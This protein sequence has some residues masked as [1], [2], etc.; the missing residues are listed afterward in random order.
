MGKVFN[1]VARMV[2]FRDDGNND[3]T[4]Y[5]SYE[6]KL[7][8]RDYWPKNVPEM[9]FISSIHWIDRVFKNAQQAA[10]RVVNPDDPNTVDATWVTY[11]VG[12]EQ[13]EPDNVSLYVIDKDKHWSNAVGQGTNIRNGTLTSAIT[14][15]LGKKGDQIFVFL[16]G[17]LL[18][19]GEYGGIGNN[20]A[21]PGV[22][23]PTGG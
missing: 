4:I 9:K 20:T 13:K 14:A 3:N 16:Y 15:R 18:L 2:E 6:A 11:S 5:T 10:L 23:V 21:N 22:K 19:L 12:D 1:T 7:Y 8:V 17:T